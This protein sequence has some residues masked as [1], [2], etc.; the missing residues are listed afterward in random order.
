MIFL[1]NNTIIVYCWCIIIIS[2][3]GRGRVRTHRAFPRQIYSLMALHCAIS[4]IIL[5]G[6]PGF[7]PRLT[8]SES[9]VLPLNYSPLF[10]RRTQIRTENDGFGDRNDNRFTIRPY[11]APVQEFEP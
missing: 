3:G 7:E 11:L 9:V 1:L 2:I 8:E 5:A 4:P 6:E 10:G